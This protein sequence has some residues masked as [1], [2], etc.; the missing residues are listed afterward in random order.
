MTAAEIV[1]GTMVSTHSILA[2]F[3]L[4]QAL[5]TS[6]LPHLF[7]PVRLCTAWQQANI[8]PQTF[9]FPPFSSLILECYSAVEGKKEKGKYWR[10]EKGGRKWSLVP[11]SLPGVATGKLMHQNSSNTLRI[12]FIVTESIFSIYVNFTCPPSE[13]E[14]EQ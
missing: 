3:A 7:F 13:N 2:L 5:P 4:L 11:I 6:L 9:P 10:D 14:D 12:I 8:A 1:I